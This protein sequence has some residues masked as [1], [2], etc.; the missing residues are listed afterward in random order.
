MKMI[1]CFRG[2]FMQTSK[3]KTLLIYKFLEENSD[4]SNPISTSELISM[5]G[6]KGI[7]A[8]RKSIYAD[9][10]A[11]KQIG[12]DIITVRAPIKGGFFIASRKFELP[13][14]RLLI[15]AVFSAGFITPKKTKILIEKLEGLISL[16]QAK[17]LKSQ[18]YCE[19]DNKCDNE[20]VYYVIDRLDEAINKRKQVKFTYRRRNIDKENKK[21]YSSKVFTVSPYAL[22]WKGDHY[23]LVCNNSKYDNL[24]N[25]RLDRIKKIE[26]LDV[27]QRKV[28]EVSDY[29][30][31]FDAADYTSKMFN[32]F[33]GETDE[34]KLLCKLS[35]IEEIIDRFGSRIPLMAVDA[36]HFETR[37]N[38][39]VSDGLVSWI[40]QYGS[41]I[42][43]LE[44]EY[45]VDM[46]SDKAK[47]ILQ[48]Y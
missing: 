39:A 16:N 27:P 15:D 40:M 28:S 13:E 10:E 35:L 5:L 11:L 19:G 6:E 31:S 48:L 25:L 34:V 42:K 43:V 17:A 14:V 45:L 24:M 22:I 1:Q 36:N 18:V 29:R 23:Y 8:E 20:E 38:A 7:K 32:M 41:D 37:I 21:T 9:I 26:I 4:E 12:C 46:V 3:L 33:S 30:K 47:S 2:D 44:P